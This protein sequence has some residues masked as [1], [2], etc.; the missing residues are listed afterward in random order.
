MLLTT[1]ELIVVFDM[2]SPGA[3][4]CTTMPGGRLPSIVLFVIT[5]PVRTLP[6]TS[7]ARTICPI[8]GGP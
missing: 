3:L 6:G 5:V 7:A 8:A 1:F 4:A 2:T